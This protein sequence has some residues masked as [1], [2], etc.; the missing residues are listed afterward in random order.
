MFN[1]KYAFNKLI[2]QSCCI[3]KRGCGEFQRN[4]IRDIFAPMGL[5]RYRNLNSKEKMM[6]FK[7]RHLYIILKVN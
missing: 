3:Q 4:I 1:A 6:H 2:C 7:G 5:L